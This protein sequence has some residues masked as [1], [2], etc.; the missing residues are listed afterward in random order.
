MRFCLLLSLPARPLSLPLMRVCLCPAGC[1]SGSE[2]FTLLNGDR[3]DS[4]SKGPDPSSS[5][6][7]LG[8]G[9]LLLLYKLKKMIQDTIERRLEISKKLISQRALQSRF[10]SKNE[11]GEG[12]LCV[13][14]AAP[15]GRSLM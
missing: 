15:L 9:R 5:K 6:A 8:S 3:G 14:F 2:P 10:T 12:C 4:K 1:T 13:A 7:Q 11:K